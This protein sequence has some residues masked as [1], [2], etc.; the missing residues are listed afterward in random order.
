M[1]KA[2]ELISQLNSQGLSNAEIARRLGKYDSAIISRV[3]KGQRPGTN[4]V[5]PLQALAGGKAT[6]EV[7][8]AEHQKRIIYGTKGRILSYSTNKPSA[9]RLKQILRQANKAG[10]TRAGIV[11]D[12]GKFAGY[13]DRKASQN[14]VRAYRK[15]DTPGDILGRLSASGKS[16]ADFLLQDIQHSTGAE[17]V[18]DLR[19][20]TI[21]FYYG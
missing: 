15:G 3:A 7:P 9:A 19:G 1:A 2:A 16:G 11:A 5:G 17:S 14:V 6:A 13:E 4:L 20:V 10:A 8:K 12:V 21:N 18:E